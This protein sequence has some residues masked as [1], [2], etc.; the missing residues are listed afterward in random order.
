MAETFQQTL[1]NFIEIDDFSGSAKGNRFARHTEHHA[2]RFAL[3]EGKRARLP[4]RQQP[5]CA[6]GSHSGKD[7]GAGMCAHQLCNGVKENVYRR[8]MTVDGG[9]SVSLTAYPFP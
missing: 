5:T 7:G 3:S 9:A 4:Q 2:A 1:A 8:A 6:V